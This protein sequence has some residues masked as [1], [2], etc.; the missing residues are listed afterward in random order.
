[1]AAALPNMAAC[2][3]RGPQRVATTVTTI[4]TRGAPPD[5]DPAEI[6]RHLVAPARGGEEEEA[7]QPEGDGAE[8]PIHSRAEMEN[9]K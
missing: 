1:M 5:H 6:G 2:H 9:R 8:A 4:R 3:Q 7:R